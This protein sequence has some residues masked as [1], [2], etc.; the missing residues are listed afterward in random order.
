MLAKKATFEPKKCLIFGKMVGG[1][2]MEVRGK[3]G[4]RKGE[5]RISELRHSLPKKTENER[6][7]MNKKKWEN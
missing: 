2:K 5:R 1:K 7:G 4:G 6:R 3:M